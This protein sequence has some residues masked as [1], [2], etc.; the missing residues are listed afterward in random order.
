MHV[1]ALRVINTTISYDKLYSFRYDVYKHMRLPTNVITAL[2][3]SEYG[4]KPTLIY[5]SKRRGHSKLSLAHSEDGLRF[6]ESP[7]APVILTSSHRS[8]EV[9]K[10]NDYRFSDVANERLLTYSKSGRL[11]IARQ[12]PV[13]DDWDLPL[14]R[15]L[16]TKTPRAQSGMFVPEF[17]HNGQYVLYYNT[18][19]IS[20][21]LSKDL[22][23]WHTPHKPIL[24]PRQG[25]FDDKTLRVI[26]VGLV[27]KGILVLFETTNT[28]KRKET[29]SVG[30]AL[31]ERHNPAKLIWRS[32]TPLW[33]T[34]ALKSDELRSIGGLIGN[35]QILLY[36]YSR[37]RGV[38]LIDLPNPV[39]VSE[40]SPN[41][42]LLLNRHHKNPIIAPEGGQ[43]WEQAG[44]FNPAAIVHGG[45]VHLFY[46]AMSHDGISR[47]GYAHS[48]DGLHFDRHTEV[49]YDH[50]VD[51]LPPA[52]KP[53]EH[54]PDIY[55]SG[56]GWGG[57]EDPRAV[58]I[59]DHLYLSFSVFESWQSMRQAVIDMPLER[60][61]D[62]RWEWN[63]LTYI[64]PRGETN[65]NWML[66]PEKIDGKYAILHALTP[67]VHIDYVEDLKELEQNPFKSNSQ[68]SGRMGAWDGF[69]RGASAP[70]VKTEHGWLLFYHGM[71]PYE[72]Q[73]GYKVGAMLLDLEDPTKIIARSSHP[74]LVPSVWYENEHKY[75]VVYASG[76]VIK[77]DELFIYYGGGDRH[78]CVATA[79]IE[80][81]MEALLED[82]GMHI[83]TEETS[84]VIG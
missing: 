80:E 10:T 67:H 30:A 46:R 20:V 51:A 82:T 29:I 39:F 17:K 35:E 68:R 48:K 52:D 26:S 19:S 47:F 77:D 61:N 40:I 54:N 13:A 79:P 43:D 49:V 32:E 66:F 14:W 62:K 5:G 64:S 15:T 12:E 74:I 42:Q 59:D 21:T 25:R 4:Q 6:T 16:R 23:T 18:S 78:V 44:T 11:T 53:L 33:Q 81:F 3:V 34:Q 76:A 22:K 41:K 8:E 1:F 71:N 83:E 58:V 70:P 24:E 9:G 50:G 38:M 31:F 75:G 7:D 36:A 28:Y 56:G 69:V 27:S 84:I 57:S 2:G 65:K 63:P 55:A 60:L 45:D 73:I 37:K 72:P